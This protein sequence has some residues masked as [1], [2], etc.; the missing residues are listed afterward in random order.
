MSAV[1]LDEV[2]TRAMASAERLCA[3]RKCRSR[4]TGGDDVLSLEAPLGAG[5]DIRAPSGGK[6]FALAAVFN[7]LDQ[8]TS[9]CRRWSGYKS[10]ISR[11]TSAVRTWNGYGGY[12]KIDQ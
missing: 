8:D 12:R 3:A 1:E 9:R 6:L 2:D 5:Q 4:G 7:I 11:K 10:E